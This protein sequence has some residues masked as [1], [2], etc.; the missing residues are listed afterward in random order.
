M[1]EIGESLNLE[2][3]ADDPVIVADDAAVVALVRLHHARDGQLP[4]VC[5]WIT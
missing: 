2:G 1:S 3:V 5:R 4:P